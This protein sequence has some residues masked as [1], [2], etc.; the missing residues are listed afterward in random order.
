MIET[1]LLK[2]PTKTQSN[3]PT[4]LKKGNMQD[5]A[6]KIPRNKHTHRVKEKVYTDFKSN[7]KINAWQRQ[8][9][10]RENCD[11]SLTCTHTLSLL[12]QSFQKC[13]KKIM[14]RMH[15]HLSVYIRFT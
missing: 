10:I 12:T 2:K 3:Q 14:K 6:Q 9:R 7:T 15:V 8:E 1:L 11:M 5:S 4:P 13:T